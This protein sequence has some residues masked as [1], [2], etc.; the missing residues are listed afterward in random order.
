M[1]YGD[2]VSDVDIAASVEFHRSH[3]K[4]VTITSVQPLSRYGALGLDGSTVTS[5]RE[6]PDEE[7]GWI[8]GGFFVLSPAAIDAVGDENQMFEREPIDSLVAQGEVRSFAH[9]GFWHA[10]DTLRDKMHLEEL[11]NKGKAPWKSW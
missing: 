4:L 9:H 11:W 2:G 5:F 10:M 7:G 3:G 1:T 6:K 8:N